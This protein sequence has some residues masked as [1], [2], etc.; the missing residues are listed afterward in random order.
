MTIRH[1][2]VESDDQAAPTAP[3]VVDPPQDP[4]TKPP[5]GSAARLRD[6]LFPVVAEQSRRRR[7]AVWVVVLVAA[8]VYLAFR[9]PGVGAFD[10]VWAED[11]ADFLDDAAKMGTLEAVT[12]PVN[13]YY[14]LYPRLLAEITTLFP[15]SWWAVVNTVF[16]IAT[17]CAMA[18]VVYQASAGHFR[19]PLVRLAVAAPVVLQ[20]VANGEAVN[21]V[22]TVQF[23]AL[24]TGFWLLVYVAQGRVG[25]IG[26]PVVVAMVSLTTILALALVPLALL[27][28]ALRRDRDSLWLT[29]ATGGGVLVQVLGAE[30]GAATRDGIGETTPDPGWVVESFRKIAVPATFLGES[31][32]KTIAD[33]PKLWV[34]AWLVLV[35]AVLVSFWRALRPARLFAALAFAYA[36][37]VFAMEIVAMG[38]VPG[39]YLVVPS[40]LL[41]TVVVALLRPQDAAPP[42]DPPTGGRRGLASYVPLVVLLGLIGHLS[43]ANYRVDHQ[44][45]TG[46]PSWT[47]QVDERAHECQ[48]DPALRSVVVR[49]GPERTPYSRVNVPCE[50]LR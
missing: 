6:A 5:A 26:G 45:R 37:G 8:A 13:G 40:F 47:A 42:D 50:R 41:V 44:S 19:R 34:V 35:A 12:R 14:L 23:A 46:L 3:P 11:G 2:R 1:D 43:V 25:R 16:A 15:V 32:M 39:R 30:S 33:H 22:A 28:L 7:L 4:P 18:A 10:T 21:N 31:A 36:L 49:S 48:D 24:Y 17:T 27:R 20:W 9:T 29:V 38:R